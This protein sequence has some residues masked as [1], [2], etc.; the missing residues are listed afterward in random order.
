M[1]EKLKKCRKCKKYKY[2]SLYD[3]VA[4]VFCTKCRVSS[5]KVVKKPPKL[6]RS[7]G[8]FKWS[9]LTGSSLYSRSRM[10]YVNYGITLENYN[11]MLI[12]QDYKCKI[13]KRHKSEFIKPLAVDHCHDSGKIRGLLCGACNIALGLF[14][15]NEK[16]L[17]E[18]IKYLRLNK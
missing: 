14:R 3:N 18:A 13:C 16:S 4:D 10:L 11:E 2:I 12:L 1:E 8:E 17:K 9:G 15:D 6:R 7:D 5:I